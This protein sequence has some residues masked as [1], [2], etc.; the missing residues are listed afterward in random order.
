MLLVQGARRP[1]KRGYSEWTIAVG[2]ASVE[3]LPFA[4]V[5]FRI[6]MPGQEWG[7]GE[8][9][10]RWRITHLGK[11]GMEAGFFIMYAGAF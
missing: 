2:G 9:S 6:H 3:H 7:L 8:K 4:D 5:Y 1:G 10:G 11:L